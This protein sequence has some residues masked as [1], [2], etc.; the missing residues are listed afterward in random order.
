MKLRPLAAGGVHH[1]TDV[2]PRATATTAVNPSADAGRSL[3]QETGCPL[4]RH[5]RSTGGQTVTSNRS[6]TKFAFVTVATSGLSLHLLGS[7]TDALDLK[8]RTEHSQF[9]RTNR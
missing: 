1:G 8:T 4:V 6:L 7:P 5:T 2:H 9:G 3:T